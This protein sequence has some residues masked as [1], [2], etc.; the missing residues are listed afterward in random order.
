[1]S[2]VGNRAPGKARWTEQNGDNAFRARGA[3]D[4]AFIAIDN[5]CDPHLRAPEM[6]EITADTLEK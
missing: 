5:H 2:S 6:A 4:R 1:M 3:S